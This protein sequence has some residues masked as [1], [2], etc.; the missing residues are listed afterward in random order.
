MLP[1]STRTAE[2]K[3]ANFR[4]LFRI[5]FYRLISRSINRLTN[6]LA[7]PVFKVRGVYVNRD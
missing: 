2:R 4:S 3:Y 5:H 6:H 1:V 7:W